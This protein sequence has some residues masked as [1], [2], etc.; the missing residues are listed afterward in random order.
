[1]SEVVWSGMWDFLVW[2]WRGILAGGG[3]RFK[4]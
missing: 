2:F 3:T 4:A 1:V